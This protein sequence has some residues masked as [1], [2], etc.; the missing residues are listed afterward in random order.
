MTPRRPYRGPGPDR[1]ADI[2]LPPGRMPLF[3]RGRM[4][5]RWRYVGVY[6]A[7]L[8]L[9]A[10]VARIG[11]A[12]QSWW[13][14]W[15]RDRDRLHERTRLRGGGV[16]LGERRVRVRDGAVE[17]DLSL[18]Y[19]GAEEVEVVTPDGRGY[20]WTRKFAPVRA[21]GSVRV[22]GGARTVDA[23]AL[24]DDSAGYH[25]RHTSWRWSAGVGTVASDGGPVAWNLVAGVHDSPTASE[26]TVW[27]GGQAR[28]LGPVSFAE[29]LGA[30]AFAEGGRLEFEAGAVRAR[31]D[32][33][34]IIR[35]E[36]EQPFGTFRGTLPG[37]LELA[38]G[39]GV[40]ERHVAVW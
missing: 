6:A 30:V 1:P 36:Y 11:P 35:S 8:M 31:D 24:I 33:L 20:A 38:E 25:A 32:N 12:R 4:L 17:M 14:V 10:G 3:R 28:E 19:D 26:R 5:K 40:M 16:D 2:P 9:C 39:Y 27:A 15:E 18:D 22:D 7:D 23:L 21:R 29:D 34:L 13:A 37:G